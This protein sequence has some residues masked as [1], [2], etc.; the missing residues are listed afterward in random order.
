MFKIVRRLRQRSI[1]IIFISHRLEELEGLL[2][3]VTVLRDGRHVA[4]RPAVELT[5]DEVVRLANGLPHAG[6]DQN[7][8]SGADSRIGAGGAARREF[9]PGGR[10]RERFFGYMATYLGILLK[11]KKIANKAGTSVDL[12]MIGQRSID[13][14]GTAN[15]NSMLFFTKGHDDFDTGISMT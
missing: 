12:P 3:T 14:T 8:N 7:V 1:S 11:S 6:A 15:L 10:L 9:G 13:E 4:T 5:Q 2:D